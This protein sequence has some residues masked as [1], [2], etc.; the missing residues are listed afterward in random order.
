V[1]KIVKLAMTQSANDQGDVTQPISKGSISQ[2]Q[3]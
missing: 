2:V 3:R 1:T